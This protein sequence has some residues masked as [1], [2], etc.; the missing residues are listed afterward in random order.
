MFMRLD[1]LIQN[2][3]P[4]VIVFFLVL[5][6]AANYISIQCQSQISLSYIYNGSNYLVNYSSSWYWSSLSTPHLFCN[7]LS[8]LQ[9]TTKLVFHSRSKHIELDYHLV[10][11][12][13]VVEALV[14]HFL[15][16]KLQIVDI[17]TKGFPKD[18]FLTFYY[19]LGVHKIPHTS[20]RKVTTYQISNISK[21]KTSS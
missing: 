13:V 16:S 14:T 15:P 9:M 2:E 1:V 19:K 11:E 6:K 21:K 8:A 4:Q 18:L 7:N 10:R 12:N 20:F 3:A 5:Q 17:F